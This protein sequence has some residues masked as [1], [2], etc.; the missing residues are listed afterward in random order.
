MKTKRNTQKQQQII[1][2]KTSPVKDVIGFIS[3]LIIFVVLIPIILYKRKNFNFLEVYLPNV[4]LIANLLTWIRGP[5]NIWS[6]LYKDGNSISRFTSQTLINYIALLGVTFIIARETK[7][8][9]N[10]F[11]GWSLAFVMLLA[12]YLL[13]TNIVTWFMEKSATYSESLNINPITTNI[14]SFTTGVIVTLSFLFTEI[15]IL[16]KYKKHIKGLA[17]FIYK[18]PTKIKF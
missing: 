16:Q 1:I 12:S 11:A 18:I 4:D 7:K 14:F 2:D 6:D 15:F 5:Y 9:N 13:P 3:F 8:T 10:I 17:K